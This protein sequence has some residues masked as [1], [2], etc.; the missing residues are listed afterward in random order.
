MSAQG[1][2]RRVKDKNPN[3][4]D[5][6]TPQALV[7]GL[8]RFVG[9]NGFT[10]DPCVDPRYPKGAKAPAWCLGPCTGVPGC[11]CGLCAPW[12]GEEVFVNPPFS[13]GGLWL[14]KCANEGTAGAGVVALVTASTGSQWFAKAARSAHL[15]Y[16]PT[17]RVSYIDP[18]TGLAVTSNTSDSAIFVWLGTKRRTEDPAV[19]IRPLAQL[20][21]QG[22]MI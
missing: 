2:Q 9:G 1:P 21:G 12:E 16:L 17:G 14:R 5:W 15:I 8:S 20:M 3:R 22:V 7:D 13:A 4:D 10:L 18:T 6:M 19:F 11:A